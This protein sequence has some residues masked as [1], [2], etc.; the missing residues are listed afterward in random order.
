MESFIDLMLGWGLGHGSIFFEI[1][2]T[3]KKFAS[4]NTNVVQYR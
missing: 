1:D 2:V 3:S 4:Y